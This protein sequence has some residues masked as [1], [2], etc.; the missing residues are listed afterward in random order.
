MWKCFSSLKKYIHVRVMMITVLI[1]VKFLAWTVNAK[2]N[3][4]LYLLIISILKYYRG[5]M[6]T[7]IFP[8]QKNKK[9]TASSAKMWSL[10]TVNKLS[11]SILM[12]YSREPLILFLIQNNWKTMK[13]SRLDSGK[14]K[15]KKNQ[16][17]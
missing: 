11:L 13:N 1:I 6:V 2:F 9:K 5:V 12:R 15:R 16:L 3:L 7:T 8:K 14:L 4:I 17:C 10:E